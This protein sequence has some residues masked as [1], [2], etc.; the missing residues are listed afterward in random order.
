MVDVERICR[1]AIVPEHCAGQRLDQTAAKLWPEFSRSRLKQW[2]EAGQL[3]VSGATL[4]PKFKLHG[5]ETLELDAEQETQVPLRP[6]PIPLTIVHADSSI[7]VID[8]PAGLVVHPGAGNAGGTLQNALLSYDPNLAVV[9]RAGIVHRLDK[10]TSGLL[11]IARTLEAHASL[12]AQIEAREVHRT[13]QAVCVGALTGGGE[14]N[15]PIGRHPKDRKRMTVREDGRPARSVYRVRERFRAHTHIDV[16]LDTGRTHQIRVH[17][18]HLRMPLVGDPVYGGRPRLPPAPSEE[19]IAALRGM[20][21]QALHAVRLEFKHPKT[22]EQ[23]VYESP[24]A[25]D[26]V[27][28]I[29][30]LRRDARSASKD[31]H[32]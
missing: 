24:L 30:V 8:K 29:D 25:D 28:L 26:L 19:M 3:Q 32:K 13:Y 15:A 18:A 9:P 31:A 21:R 2:I 17:M 5:G 10:D 27:A 7:I 20:S 16:H 1:T 14:I 4:A 23:V 11:M 22:G 6:E 12:A